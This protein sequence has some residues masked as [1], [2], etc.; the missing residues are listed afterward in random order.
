V[1]TVGSTIPR[2][3]G[4]AIA[5]A[6]SDVAAALAGGAILDPA[7]AADRAKATS[8]VAA[9]LALDVEISDKVAAGPG[10][11]ILDKVAEAQEL[12]GAI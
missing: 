10:R 4:P 9:A 11:V 12:D 2:T 8:D 5:Q 7:E 1:A 6:I 3:E